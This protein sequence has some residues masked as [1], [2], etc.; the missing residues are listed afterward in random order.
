MIKMPVFADSIKVDD[1]DLW[2]YS[3]QAPGTREFMLN[4]VKMVY[5]SFEYFHNITSRH[6]NH[7]MVASGVV[8]RS[9]EFTAYRLVVDKANEMMKDF[10]MFLERAIGTSDKRTKAYR[11]FIERREQY[12]SYVMERKLKDA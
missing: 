10:D 5:G 11:S 3:T 8:R 6:V 1:L 2:I 7:C 4:D 9:G 12:K